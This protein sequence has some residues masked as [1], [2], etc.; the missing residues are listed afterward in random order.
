MRFSQIAVASVVLG[1]F[2]CRM[3]EEPAMGPTTAINAAPEAP[4]GAGRDAGSNVTMA[5]SDA[6]QNLGATTAA[7]LKVTQ[8]EHGSF[9]LEW[10]GKA[11]Y[12]DPGHDLKAD[13]LPK[14]DVI[15]ITHSHEH[16]R[17]TP[18]VAALKKGD[19]SI[20]VPA[21]IATG[22]GV[23]VLANGDHKQVGDIGVEAVPMY[24]IKRGPSAG[25]VFH[26]KGQGNGYILTLGDK[27]VY[28]SG[29]TE[30]TPEMKALKNIDVA[31]VSLNV[32]HTMPA[33]E[34]AE[35]VKAFQPK[36]VYP[37]QYSRANI[38]EFKNALGDQQIEVRLMDSPR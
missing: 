10:G 38:D 16:A 21:G 30:C 6:R 9:L 1:A 28:L 11:I 15:L 32:P 5:G 26:E 20:V 24:N 34:A 18:E 35:C 27:R 36:V 7:A 37:Y 22:A 19:G 3:S 31:F 29:D 8:L 25:H 2:A 23:V 4:I 33:S 12:V 13:K 14:A 17:A